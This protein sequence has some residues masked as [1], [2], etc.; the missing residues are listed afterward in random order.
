MLHIKFCPKKYCNWKRLLTLKGCG[1]QFDPP[2][3]VFQEMCFLGEG[4][5][6]FF[7]TFNIFKTHIFPKM[8]LKFL[9][10]FR[11]YEDFILQY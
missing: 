5:A 6:I 2:F 1:G 10:S 9:K 7:V 11:R 4:E 8:S 3:V